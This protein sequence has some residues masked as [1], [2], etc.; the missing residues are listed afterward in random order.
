[1]QDITIIFWSVVISVL[2]MI[3]AVTI[4]KIFDINIF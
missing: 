3:I 2:I 4:I 1:M